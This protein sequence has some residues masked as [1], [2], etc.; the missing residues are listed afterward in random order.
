MRFFFILTLVVFGSRTAQAGTSEE[1]MRQ[2][3]ATALQIGKSAAAIQELK[4]RLERRAIEHT[5]TSRPDLQDFD[6][7]FYAWEIQQVV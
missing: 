1:T 5:L 4:T 3:A 2:V 7:K 6:L